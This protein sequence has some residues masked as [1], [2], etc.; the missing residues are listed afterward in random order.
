MGGTRR[1]TRV[2]CTRSFWCRCVPLRAIG[3]GILVGVDVGSTCGVFFGFV[4]LFL[5]CLFLGTRT[6]TFGRLGVLSMKVSV[7]ARRNKKWQHWCLT[8]ILKAKHFA[9]TMVK[10]LAPCDV[11][12]DPKQPGTFYLFLVV[13]IFFEINLSFS[14][15]FSRLMLYLSG[16]CVCAVKVVWGTM[17]T[18]LN[19]R[20]RDWN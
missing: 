1:P 19:S 2:S 5:V 3:G 16:C 12:V 14:N 17:P 6:K 7:R 8:T 11:C 9:K 18:R 15:P 4:F 13:F 10:S 20:Q